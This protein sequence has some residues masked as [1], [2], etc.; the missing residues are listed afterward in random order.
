MWLFGGLSSMSSVLCRGLSLDPHFWVT[1]VSLFCITSTVSAL[2]GW[3]GILLVFCMIFVSLALS[4]SPRL[5]CS[6]Y[7]IR[8]NCSVLLSLSSWYLLLEWVFERMSERRKMWE[9][10]LVLA[11]R[12]VSSQDFIAGVWKGL[13]R[14][15]CIQDRLTRILKLK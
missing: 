12:P 10:S 4:T 1:A 8:V 14:N 11:S 2:Q 6:P 13:T 7:L 9:V 5:P 3:A 15:V